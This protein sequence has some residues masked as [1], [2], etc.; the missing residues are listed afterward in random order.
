VATEDTLAE[1]MRIPDRANAAACFGAPV[2]SGDRTVIPVADISYGF[3]AGWG[4]SEPHEMSPG[5]RGGGA[6]GGART[7]AI[8]VIEV[9]PNGVRIL[10]I[11]DQTSIRIAAITFAS[12]ATA[13]LAR[14]ILKL[15]R[16]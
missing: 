5:G 1:V 4:S 7:R 11:E 10:P 6:G 3:G 15:I 12:A 16:G 2:T 14:T 8:A 13:I 9:A